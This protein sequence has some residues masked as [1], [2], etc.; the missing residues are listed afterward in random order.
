MCRYDTNK[1]YTKSGVEHRCD[2]TDARLAGCVAG[3]DRKRTALL[4]G[5]GVIAWCSVLVA[6]VR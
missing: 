3:G 2:F 4:A 1:H 6:T 5:A